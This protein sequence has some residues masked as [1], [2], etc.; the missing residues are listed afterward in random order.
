[1]L[2]LRAP[3]GINWVRRVRAHDHPSRSHGD[4]DAN[5][6]QMFRARRSPLPL[7]APPT[8]SSVLPCTGQWWQLP[9]SRP[10]ATAKRQRPQQPC[11]TSHFRF[12]LQA[13][14]PLET[15]VAPGLGT[16]V[17][18]PGWR[19]RLQAVNAP[20]SARGGN[21]IADPPVISCLTDID[22]DNIEE[23][24]LQH[25]RPPAP[26]GL[27]SRLSGPR[28]IVTWPSGAETTYVQGP[29]ARA[30]TCMHVRIPEL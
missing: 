2:R 15:A 27:V 13:R 16:I 20:A 25:R 1:M 5:S 3:F 23:P 22:V 26:C 9:R 6:E 28:E 17:P 11:L 4:K 24:L 14:A 7:R 10:L 18:R 19:H 21:T 29:R 30:Y 8:A 12:S